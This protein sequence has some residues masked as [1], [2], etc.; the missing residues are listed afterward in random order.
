MACSLNNHGDFVQICVSD[1]YGD[2]SVLK[3][4][5]NSILMPKIA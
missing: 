2:L 3:L 1:E 5:E 4:K